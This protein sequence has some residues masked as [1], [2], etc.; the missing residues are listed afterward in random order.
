MYWLK[1]LGIERG[2]PFNPDESQKKAL[3][4]GAIVGETMAKTMVFSERLD[5]VLRWARATS[6][7]TT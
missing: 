6:S 2:K 3:L 5:G 4:E 1:N 7:P